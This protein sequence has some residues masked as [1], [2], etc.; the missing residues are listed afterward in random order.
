MAGLRDLGVREIGAG[1][2]VAMARSHSFADLE[3]Q[4]SGILVEGVVAD[5]AELLAWA[6]PIPLAHGEI[7]EVVVPG[8]DALTVIDGDEMA[9]F[10]TECESPNHSDPTPIARNKL[11]EVRRVGARE[12]IFRPTQTHEMALARHVRGFENPSTRI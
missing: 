4:M 11:S 2:E 6:Y 5:A 8:G 9:G 7:R 12:L 3:V 10:V 1:V